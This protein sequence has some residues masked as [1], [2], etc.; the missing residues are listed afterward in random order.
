MIERGD[1]V[2]IGYYTQEAPEMDQSLKAIDYIKETAEIVKDEN[3]GYI[4][5]SQMMERFLFPGE[6]QHA[7][8][9]S[10][11]G[12]ERRR[13]YLLKILMEAPN[14]LL[15]DEPTN[16]LD[17]DTLKALED[18]IDSY[19]GIVVTVSHDRY[20][21]DRIC[22]V[23]LAI[24]KGNAT[25]HTGNYEDYMADRVESPSSSTVSAN[26]AAPSDSIATRGGNRSEKLS[27]RE[28][29][30]LNNLGGEIETMMER[31]DS[32]ESEM[33][34]K[35]ADFTALQ[36]LTEEQETIEMELLEKMERLE[37]LQEKA[38]KIKG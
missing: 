32:I 4:T 2:K 7:P 22:N 18:Y 8:I 29:Q 12:G 30:D 10:M 37:A 33:T 20:F 15:L 14:V 11:S 34:E 26:P 6:L 16:D 5:A 23:I 9:H 21:L 36:E 17:I 24:D 38:A 31:L 19:K 28:K 27:Y 13:L 25:I 3:G 1:T 35:A